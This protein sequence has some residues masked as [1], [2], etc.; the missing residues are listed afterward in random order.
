MNVAY[1]E[2]ARRSMERVRRMLFGAFRI[3]TWLV[4]GFAAF[5]SE[6]LGSSSFAGGSGRHRGGFHVTGKPEDLQ[7]ALDW[8][9]GALQNP[10]YIGLL[11]WIILGVTVLGILFLY[12][13]SRGKFVFLDDV[14]RERAAI[15]EPWSRFGRQAT[16]LFFFRLV[17]T[18]LL[19]GMVVLVVMSTGWTVVRELLLHEPDITHVIGS[20]LGTILLMCGLG[21]LFAFA[22]LMLNSFVVPIMHRHGV[23]VLEAWRRFLPLFGE[24]IVG[25][26]VYAVM[27]L[28]LSALTFGMVI[29]V[30]LATCCIGFVLMSVPYVGQVVLLPVYVFF[31]SLGPEFLAQF[32]PE[33]DVFAARPRDVVDAPAP[34]SPGP[35]A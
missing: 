16:S 20:L 33:W 32:G 8:I 1:I 21:T 19:I 4:L 31:R 27:V 11:G 7:P 23:G 17:M 2:P 34:P 18:L 10:L 14:V 30:G 22:G 28:L 25:F 6:W 29:I 24:H 9:R 12:L 5:L 35:T 26:L 13:G 3:E 15:V